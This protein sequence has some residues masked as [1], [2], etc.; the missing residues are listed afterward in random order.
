MEYILSVVTLLV[1]IGIGGACIWLFLQAKIQQ[2]VA[3]ARAEAEAERATLVE[4]L[5]NREQAAV[6]AKSTIQHKD[7]ELRQQHAT[8]SELQAKLAQY[9]TALQAE[10]KQSQ[11]KL[12]LVEDAKKALSDQFKALA[13][14]AL[15]SNNQSF[16]DLAKTNFDK[17]QETAQSDLEKRQKAIETLV[18]PVKESLVKVDLKIQELEKARVG[19]YSGITEQI[20]SLV[21]GQLLLRSETSNLVR[22]LRTPTGRGQWGE[23]QLRRV[24]EMAGMLNHCDFYEQQSM[25]TEGGP[26]R[27][28]LL[29]RLSA[30]RNIIV[31]AKTP[32]SAYLESVEAQDDDVRKLKLQ[33]HAQQ[34]RTHL[35]A[36]GKKSY[37]ENF[38]PTPEFVVMFLP[39]E[40]FFCAALTEDPS[41][42]EFGV[43][44]NVIVAT[45]TTLIALLRAVAYGWRQEALAQ[46][47][48]EISDLGK[49]LYDRCSKM[50]GHMANLGKNLGS[51]TEAYNRA[52]GSLESRVLVT[53]RKFA[54][55]GAV[56][57]DGQIVEMVPVEIVP[58]HLQAPELIR[59]SADEEANGDGDLPTQPR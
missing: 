5:Q 30:S 8:V 26:L 4:R 22:A 37:C 6:E 59:L 52:V 35:I 16:L 41:L 39:G 57:A 50:G 45:P 58:R 53:A 3:N 17:H 2:A 34:V 18:T 54:D 15:K 7:T 38:T 33:Q 12:A 20:K 1:G 10:R 9:H 31:D 43:E 19:A 23:I 42:I 11:E 36:L 55:L 49:E 47:A 14:D 32:L 51:A 27:P 29:V 21:D 48:K 25:A 44:Q 28:D 46:N 24:V 40:A 13:S 56:S